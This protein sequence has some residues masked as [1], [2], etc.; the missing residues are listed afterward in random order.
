[1]RVRFLHVRPNTMKQTKLQKQA[2][3][4]KQSAQAT[5]IKN[6]PKCTVEE[7]E[8]LFTEAKDFL[9]DTGFYGSEISTASCAVA[10]YMA[11]LS[12][13]SLLRSF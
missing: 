8:K 2:E 11:Y 1:M 10:E 13:K 5:L 9:R 7:Q 3:L 4:L 12:G 6:L